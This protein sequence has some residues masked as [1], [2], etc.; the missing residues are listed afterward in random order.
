MKA[1]EIEEIFNDLRDGLE[2][3]FRNS[4]NKEDLIERINELLNQ[5]EEKYTEE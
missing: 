2:F 3:H 1:E 5:I 4:E